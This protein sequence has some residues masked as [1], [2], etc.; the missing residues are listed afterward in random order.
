MEGL[1]SGTGGANLTTKTPRHEK[2]KRLAREAEDAENTKIR[3]GSDGQGMWQRA[4]AIPAVRF[5]GLRGPGL[6]T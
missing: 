1:R 4:L 6:D 3:M 2:E 5:L